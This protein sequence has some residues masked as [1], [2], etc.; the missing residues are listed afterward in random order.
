MLPHCT[1]T[2]PHGNGVFLDAGQAASCMQ[3]HT[4]ATPSV[5]TRL[6]CLFFFG[7]LYS[8]EH[9]VDFLEEYVVDAS[10]DLFVCFYTNF[11]HLSSP[12]DL[13]DHLVSDKDR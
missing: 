1:G 8:G 2:S 13:L 4:H 12:T 9:W 6:W 7:F 11:I 10:C 5:V 3:A